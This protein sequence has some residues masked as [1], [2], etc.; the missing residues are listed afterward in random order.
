MS[1]KD[2]AA[3]GDKGMQAWADRDADAFMALLADEFE[4]MDDTHSAPIRTEAEARQYMQEWFTAFPDM[5]VKTLNRV[6]GD[7]AIAAEVLFSGTNSGPLDMGGQ[8]IPATNRPINGHG[9]YFAEVTNGKIVTFHSHPNV[10][11]MM[12]Q[13]GLS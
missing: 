7:D 5:T 1:N 13:L 6:V 4:W 12:Q 11:E 10:A 2:L 8:H 9:T 3:I